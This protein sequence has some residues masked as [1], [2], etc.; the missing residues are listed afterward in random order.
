LPAG[1]AARSKGS[2]RSYTEADVKEK[3]GLLEQRRCEL[4][5]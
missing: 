5:G 1:G 3:L 4:Q 2:H